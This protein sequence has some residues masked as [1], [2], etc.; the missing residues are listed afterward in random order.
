V[1][2]IMLDSTNANAV[3]RAVAERREYRGMRIRAAALYLDGA[4][5][6]PAAAFPAIRREGVAVVGITVTGVTGAHIARIAG[7]DEPGDLT[8]ETAAQWAATESHDGEWPVIYVDRS[9]KVATITAALA[10][11]ISP[12]ADY[13]LWVGTLDGTFTDLNGADLRQEPGVVGVQVFDAK[14]LG[15]DADATVLTALGDHWLGLPPSWQTTAVT[16]AR[17]L[18]DLIRAHA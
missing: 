8:P 4:T 12:G 11:G 10:Q 13:G 15:I 3:G 2:G 17:D 14:S 6:A 16:M 1:S 9:N 5:A 18:A 7:D